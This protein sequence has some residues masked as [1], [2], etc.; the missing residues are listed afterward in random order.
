M[1]IAIALLLLLNAADFALTRFLC[2][3]ETGVYE[4]N[5]VAA[6]WL[7]NYGW[8]G[9]A[10]FKLATVLLVVGIATLLMRR[11]PRLGQ[12]VLG[13][14]CAAAAIAVLVG[15]YLAGTAGHRDRHLPAAQ[16]TAHPEARPL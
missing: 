15:G 14:G 4:A 16:A 9:L 12:G 8:L 13:L 3:G 7:L 6:W 11:R 1:R 2:A 5:P 10:G